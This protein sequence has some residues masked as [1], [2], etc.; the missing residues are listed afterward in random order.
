MMLKIILYAY[1][2]LIYSSRL[3]SESL[4][5][6][7]PQIFYKKPENRKNAYKTKKLI[8]K[9]RRSTIF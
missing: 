6:I 3:D 2:N 5:G 4:R 7:S 9:S 8:Q 1:S